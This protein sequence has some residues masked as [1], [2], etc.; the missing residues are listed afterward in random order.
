MLKFA[1]IP[2]LGVNS[3]RL[4]RLTLTNSFHGTDRRVECHSQSRC[5]GA[6]S[7]LATHLKKICFIRLNDLLLVGSTEVAT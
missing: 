6:V 5:T 1:D 2:R 3:G 7:S 4:D